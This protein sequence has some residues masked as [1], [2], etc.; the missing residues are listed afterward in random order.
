[1]SAGGGDECSPCRLTQRLLLLLLQPLHGLQRC[2][3][4]SLPP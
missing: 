4:A 1:M 3:I 2:I